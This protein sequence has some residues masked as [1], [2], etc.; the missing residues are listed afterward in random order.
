MHASKTLKTLTA[1]I[2]TKLTPKEE[3]L[4]KQQAK[5]EGLQPSEW[6]RRALVDAVECPPETRLVLSEVLS[7]R[8]VFLALMLDLIQGQKPT[9]S[10][11]REVVDKPKPRSLLWRKTASMRSRSNISK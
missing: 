7:V 11:I 10:R 3:S 9:E 2:T 6:C 5:T 8:R 1:S 4:I